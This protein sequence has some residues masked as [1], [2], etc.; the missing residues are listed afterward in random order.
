[1]RPISAKTAALPASA[2]SSIPELLNIYR[3]AL[4]SPATRSSVADALLNGN[5]PD[6]QSLHRV[7]THPT[8]FLFASS[9]LPLCKDTNRI[10][11]WDDVTLTMLAIPENVCIFK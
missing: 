7:C 4:H 8:P 2:T 9:F 11:K 10:Y 6:K 1:M 5:H 3:A